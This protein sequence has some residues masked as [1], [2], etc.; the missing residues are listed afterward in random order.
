[1]L[2]PHLPRC[3][4]WRV[5]APRC[6]CAVAAGEQ[7]SL[8]MG[9]RPGQLNFHTVPAQPEQRQAAGQ[10]MSRSKRAQLGVAPAPELRLYEGR[11]TRIFK[12][13]APSSSV[14]MV[15]APVPIVAM[16]GWFVRPAG[17]QEAAGRD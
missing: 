5:W 16:L 15:E 3:H 7:W 13:V 2:L 11:V 1:M 12:E 8:R 6:P 17:C 10:S 9:W 4:W 14:T